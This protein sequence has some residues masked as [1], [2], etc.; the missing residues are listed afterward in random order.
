MNRFSLQPEQRGAFLEGGRTDMRLAAVRA[1]RRLFAAEEYKMAA[2]VF[3]NV[4]HACHLS[5][6]LLSV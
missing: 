6:V 5:L 4:D 3:A 1:D 2:L